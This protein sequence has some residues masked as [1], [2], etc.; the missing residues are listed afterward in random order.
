[1]NTP[2]SKSKLTNKMPKQQYLEC[3]QTSMK[4][5]ASKTMQQPLESC[6]QIT[7]EYSH[8]NI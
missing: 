4:Y 1:M 6:W 8:T 5:N 2:N 7:Q 3:E